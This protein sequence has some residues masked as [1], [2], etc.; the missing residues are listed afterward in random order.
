MRLLQRI[1]IYIFLRFCS[2]SG[3]DFLWQCNQII[4]S[5]FS[6]FHN[7]SF[8]LTHR[9][10][11]GHTNT[12]THIQLRTISVTL[13]PS[14]VSSAR[15]HLPTQFNCLPTITQDIHRLTQRLCASTLSQADIIFSKHS[16]QIVHSLFEVYYSIIRSAIHLTVHIHIFMRECIACMCTI[17]C[18]NVPVCL[19]TSESNLFIQSC[20]VAGCIGS[21]EI[22]KSL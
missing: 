16:F 7:R 1:Y 14:F 4:S 3:I 22:N 17:V 15:H 18:E 6:F 20:L 12:Q 19:C 11:Y 5:F 2:Q 8:S 21:A 9:H 10:K 13:S